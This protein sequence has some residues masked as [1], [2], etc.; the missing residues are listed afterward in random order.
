M[1]HNQPVRSLMLSLLIA[2]GVAAAPVFAQV[3]VNVR[4]GPP[5]AQYEVVPAMAPNQVWVPGYWAWN[6]D[7]HVWI[8]GRTVVQRVGYRWE[9]DRWE[10]RDQVYYRHP[11][12]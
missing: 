11:G 2:A 12:R 3:T 1:K 5:A 4:I 10:Q 8:R 6:V 7:R 9:P